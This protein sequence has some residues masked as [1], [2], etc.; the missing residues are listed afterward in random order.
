MA[1]RE[2]QQAEEERKSERHKKKAKRRRGEEPEKGG[3]EKDEQGPGGRGDQRN[4]EALPGGGR[5]LGW[6]QMWERLEDPRKSH[7]PNL[8]YSKIKVPHAH[9]G[10]HQPLPLV[11]CTAILK[12]HTVAEHTVAE[13]T[14]ALSM[15]H[16][17]HL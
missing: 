12:T 9:T 4:K 1:C 17:P 11:T 8:V 14:L 16:T 6:R 15:S 5:G 3:R 10:C 13:H 7:V 2:L